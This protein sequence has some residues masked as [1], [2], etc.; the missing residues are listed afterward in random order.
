MMKGGLDGL[1]EDEE[2]ELEAGQDV[3][4][5]DKQANEIND[6]ANEPLEKLDPDTGESE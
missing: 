2:S 3:S 4:I 6:L 1:V 5:V